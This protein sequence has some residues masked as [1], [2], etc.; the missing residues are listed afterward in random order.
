[1][2]LRRGGSIAL[3]AVML[4]VVGGTWFTSQQIK[5]SLLEVDPIAL[6]YDVGVLGLGPDRIELERTAESAAPGVWGLE[7]ESGYARVG[8]VL[9]VTDT[10]VHLQ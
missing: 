8:Q 2:W 9:D 7:W 3:V 10:A 5:R 6:D 4:I 1:M